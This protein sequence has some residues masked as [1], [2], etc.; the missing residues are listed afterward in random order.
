MRSLFVH[1][2]FLLV[3]F[4]CVYH[5]LCPLFECTVYAAAPLPLEES[6]TSV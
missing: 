4:L 5:C 1:V 2:L 6:S 3:G